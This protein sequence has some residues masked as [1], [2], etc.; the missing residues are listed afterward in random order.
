MFKNLSKG[1]DLFREFQAKKYAG[2]KVIDI[3]HPEKGVGT[4]PLNGGPYGKTLTLIDQ[5]AY[6]TGK[7]K[8]FLQPVK[9]KG[10]GLYCWFN[11]IVVCWEGYDH[12]KDPSENHTDLWDVY[13]MH[14]RTDFQDCVAAYYEK[15]PDDSVEIIK[16][17]ESEEEVDLIE[18]KL[19]ED[20]KKA[21]T[22]GGLYVGKYYDANAVAN[23]E[24]SSSE[25]E[26]E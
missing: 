5:R 3:D 10:G 17:P 22:D 16:K 19:P 20:M 15:Y 7:K 6:K 26:E 1:F 11:A 24:D 25:S 14:K 8:T 18:D 23:D 2:L 13:W 12:K 21:I 9:G 4:I